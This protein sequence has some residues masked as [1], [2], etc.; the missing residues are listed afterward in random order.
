MLIML[1]DVVVTASDTQDDLRLSHGNPSC[2]GADL[3]RH[4]AVQDSEAQRRRSPVCD[5]TPKRAKAARP[6][7]KGESGPQCAR[8]VK[9]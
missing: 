4:G 6:P 1:V 2:S 9:R 7:P 8:T 5:V 3:Y